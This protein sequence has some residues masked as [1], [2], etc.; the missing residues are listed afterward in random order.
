MV[1]YWP[2]SSSR[3]FSRTPIGCCIDFFALAR[4]HERASVGARRRSVVWIP[5]LKV[6]LSNTSKVARK[7][8][9]SRSTRPTTTPSLR[10]L[11]SVRFLLLGWVGAVRELRGVDPVVGVGKESPPS[12]VAVGGVR[13]GLLANPVLRGY[14]CAL[15]VLEIVALRG[16]DSLVFNRPRP[17]PSPLFVASR[18]GRRARARS[19]SLH[20]RAQ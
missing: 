7:E 19:S 18:R 10:S 5:Y 15:A 2:S 1:G 6:L 11:S 20:Q 17:G 14:L 9:L 12:M 13:C 4:A 8:P 16:A 3:E